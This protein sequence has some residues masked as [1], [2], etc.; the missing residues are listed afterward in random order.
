MHQPNSFAKATH[1]RRLVSALQV[2]ADAISPLTVAAH[3]ADALGVTGVDAFVAILDSMIELIGDIQTGLTG[4]K[5]RVSHN[6]AIAA[7]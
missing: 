6:T 1:H 7:E 5:H 3:E 4:I 2:S